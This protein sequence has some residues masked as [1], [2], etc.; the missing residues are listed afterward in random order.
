MER[1]LRK[2]QSALLI[3]GLGVV[4]FGAWSIAKFVLMIAYRSDLVPDLDISSNDVL[5][6]VV[7]IVLGIVLL[8]PDLFLRLYI[9]KCARLEAKGERKSYTYVVVA[10]AM[11]AVLFI[12]VIT[13][14]VLLI[15][16]DSFSVYTFIDDVVVWLVDT[17]SA[18]AFIEVAVSSVRMK[19][20]QG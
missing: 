7:F 6:T 9:F 2:C 8:L 19:K 11:A 10:C 1:Q 5:L 4:L 16:A 14:I 17:T 15:Q 12:S 3:S 20:L 13:Q 18:S